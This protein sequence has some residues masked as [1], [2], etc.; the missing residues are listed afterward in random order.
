MTVCLVALLACWLCAGAQTRTVQLPHGKLVYTITNLGNTFTEH[1]ETDIDPEL[2]LDSHL[3]VSSDFAGNTVSAG[4]EINVDVTYYPKNDGDGYCSQL[5]LDANIFLTC[6]NANS[7]SSAYN[8]RFKGTTEEYVSKSAEDWNYSFTTRKSPHHVSRTFRANRDITEK[9]PLFYIKVTDYERN[10]IAIPE[11]Y[12]FAGGYDQK[13]WYAETVTVRFIDSNTTENSDSEGSSDYDQSDT[14]ADGDDENAGDEGWSLPDIDL[15][16]IPREIEHYLNHLFFGDPLGLEH[17]AT[18]EEAAI[19]GTIGAL[20]ALLFG[21][22]LGGGLGGAGGAAGGG[23]PSPVEGGPDGPSNPYQS[24]EDKYVTRDPD[25]SITVTDPITGEKKIYLPDGHGGYDNPL[26][27]GFP[28]EADMLEHLAYLDRN[29]DPLSQDAAT[30]ARNQ[31]AQ[32]QQW[33]EQSQRD[34]ERGYSDESAE[35]KKWREEQE[36]KTDQ[37]IKLADKYHTAAD[38]ESVRRAIKQEQIKAGI[39]SAKQEAIAAD[40]NVTVVGLESTKNVAATSLVLIPMALSGVGTVSVATMANA[41]MVQ[42]GFT[43]A[44]SVVTKVGDAYVEGKSLGKATAHGVTEGLVKVAQNYAGDIGGAAAGKLAANASN[45]TKT[46]VK[47]GT[48][49]AVVIGGKGVTE[50]LDEYAE[51][52]DLSKALDKAK[53]GMAD[54]AKKHLVNKTMEYGLDKGKEYIQSKMPSRVETTRVKADNAAKTVA[55]KQQQVTRTQ[56]Q[57]TNA[58]QRVAT[59]QQNAQRTQQQV[60][61]AQSKVSSAGKKLSHANKKLDAAQKQLNSAKTPEQVSRAQASLNKAQNDVAKAQ[62]NYTKASSQLKTAEAKNVATQKAAISAEHNLQKAQMGA[63]KAQ[64]DLKTATAQ[65]DQAMREVA[66]QQA[67]VDKFN[68]PELAH[69]S[70]EDIVGGIRAVEEYKEN[71]GKIGKNN[72]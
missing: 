32:H 49:A 67:Q 58:Q 19:I 24:I 47:L 62:Q 16:E 71:L 52:G 2:L 46:T 8:Q 17:Q 7:K 5:N 10:N 43:F 33:E 45:L 54:E 15:G 29:R 25:G 38:E 53:A 72:K 4:T 11:D 51:S 37:I 70:G 21:G 20:I 3:I 63:Q 65:R 26:G 1:R 6:L 59:A 34:A 44:D 39:E 13:S 61:Q 22:G 57:V 41:K 27:G 30:A 14:G 64:S 18:P 9:D 68:D 23:M 60:T 48:E 55:V 42:S 12:D 40:K 69:V 56:S 35:Y 31:A 50:G 28:S 36:R 66:E